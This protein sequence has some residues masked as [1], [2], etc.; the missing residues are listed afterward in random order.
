MDY[1]GLFWSRRSVLLFLSV[2]FIIFSGCSDDADL[3]DNVSGELSTSEKHASLTAFQQETIQYFNEI[4]LGFEFGG[5]TEITRKWASDLIIKVEGEQPIYL[6]EELNNIIGELNDLTTDG[7]SIRLVEPGELH[8]FR[9]YFGA[10]E[11]YA[12]LN[13]GAANFVDDN[14][15]LFFVNWDGNQNLVSADMYVDVFSIEEVFQR[16]LL[17]EE[18]TQAMGLAMDS[19]RYR[20]SI[21]QQSWTSVIDYTDIDEELIRLLYHPEMSSGLNESL[22]FA[23]LVDILFDE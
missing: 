12:R 13:P 11:D 19:P 23:R 5:A 7:V 21:F 16:H 20:E 9:I 10:G 17:R 3:P 22:A 4:A 18:L 2:Y 14:R 15:G 8:N 6:I 1:I